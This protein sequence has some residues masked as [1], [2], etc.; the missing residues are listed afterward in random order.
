MSEL[1]TS[2]MTDD[3]T[4]LD[5]EL[6]RLYATVEA[7]PPPKQWTSPPARIPT[8]PGIAPAG[9][10]PRQ[11]WVGV[12]AVALAAALV[13]AVLVN[14]SPFA[15]QA[16]LAVQLQPA[17]AGLVCKLPISALSEDHTTGFIVMNHGRAT[18]QQV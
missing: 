18:F 11:R 15:P 1:R 16:V 6:R 3:T 2:S 13:L 7:P 12:V 4:Q 5:E 9:W 8:R 17:A 10:P 14:R